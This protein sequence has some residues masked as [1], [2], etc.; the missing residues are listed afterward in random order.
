MPPKCIP[1]HLPFCTAYRIKTKL[2]RAQFKGPMMSLPAWLRGLLSYDILQSDSVNAFTV[3]QTFCLQSD[4]GALCMVSPWPRMICLYQ[5]PTSSPR[6][7]SWL[8]KYHLEWSP[9]SRSIRQNWSLSPLKFYNT[10]FGLPWHRLLQGP[11]AMNFCVCIPAL[12]S[13]HLE[14]VPILGMRAFPTGEGPGCR[15][16][17]LCRSLF[18]AERKGSRRLLA[19]WRNVHEVV[20]QS[21]HQD[22]SSCHIR[23]ISFVPGTATGALHT[24]SHF[25]LTTILDIGQVFPCPDVTTKA[26][27]S[28]SKLLSN[29]GEWLRFKLRSG[30]THPKSHKN[31]PTL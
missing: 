28:L 4:L 23:N 13:K 5:L 6:L 14:A 29:C 27:K 1:R 15:A 24:S 31:G 2:L 12:D 16:M 9:A 10:R 21:S 8:G 22:N 19:W 26:L 18:T 25:I 17:L 7:Q 11:V 30:N 20:P 3:L